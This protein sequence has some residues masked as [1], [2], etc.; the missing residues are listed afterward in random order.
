MQLFLLAL[1]S[2]CSVLPLA[3]QPLDSRLFAGMK[4]REI[5]PYRGG[6][7][8]A[9]AGI[10]N[11]PNVAFIGVSNGGVWKTTDYGHT[12]QSQ[13]D[14]QPVGSIGAIGISPADP[15]TIYVGTGEGLNRPDLAL[16]DG[17]YKSQDG[18]KTWA[19]L[20]LRDSQQIPWISVDPRDPNRLFV[21]AL[22]HPYGPNPERGIF[23]SSD[24]GRTFE[25]VLYKDE[26]T[27]GSFVE[28]DPTDP[29]IVYA[30]LWEARQGPWENSQW[31]GPGGGLF[32]STDGGTTWHP[33][34]KGLPEGTVQVDVTISP[35]D[36]RRLYASVAAGRG[37]SIYSSNDA[38]ESWSAATN[39]PRPASRI[40]GGDL[41]V[42]RVDPK[43]PDVL[44]ITSTVVWKSSDAGKTWTGI[45]GAPGG[46][47]YQNIWINPNDSHIIYI[48][49]DQGAIVSVNGGATWSSWYNQPT[50]AV[51]HVAADN[52]FPY[53]VCS[54]QQDSGSVCVRTRGNDGEITMRDWHPVAVEE[55]GYAAPDPRDPDMVYGGKLTRYNRR[56]GQVQNIAPRPLRGPDFRVVRTEPVIFSPKDPSILYFAS[57]VLW[58][59]RD[60]GNNWKQISQDLTRATWEIPASIGKY[61]GEQSA[62]PAQRGVIYAVGPS[63]LEAGIIW[64][65]TDDGLIHLTR[66]G[67]ATWTNVTPPQLLPWAKVSQLDAGHFDASTAYAAI[68]TIRLDDL[69]PHI[70]RTHD[71]GAT[72]TEIVTGIPADENVNSVRED[73]RTKGL[74]F[75]STERAVYVSF[76]DGAHWQ[77]LRLNMPASSVRDIIIKDDDLIAGTHGRGFWVLD[78]ITPLRQLDSA[79]AHKPLVLFAP[80]T[81]TRVRWDMNPDTPLPPDTPAG[82]NPPDGAILNYYLGSAASGPVTI[83]VQD[84]TGAVVRKYSSADPIPP[85]DP[86]LPIPTYWVRPPQQLETSAGMH[87]FVWDLH[88]AP[89]PG[90][91]PNYPIAAVPHDTAPPPSS[92]WA[93]PGHYK[94]T[95]TANGQSASQTLEVR[96]DPRVKTS[97]ADWQAQSSLSKTLYEQAMQASHAMQM[98]QSL[99]E[100]LNRMNKAGQAAPAAVTDTQQ[101]VTAL[102]GQEQGFFGGGGGRGGAGRQ[103]TVTALRGSL[104]ALLNLVQEADAAPTSQE[105]AAADDLH[106]Q[107]DAL[108]TRFHDFLN[109]LPGINAQLKQAGLPELSLEQRSEPE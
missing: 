85:P 99:R 7:T 58:E 44:Y 59:T 77:S 63:P 61:R 20:G 38:G 9:L 65:G 100:Q 75:A 51:Y 105:A 101:K 107:F 89:V 28:I 64:A 49:S 93:L 55:Y 42:P 1:V 66:D 33:L 97:P 37:V 14:D 30:A 88:W 62:Q 36:P 3:A 39:D 98:L 22:G 25:K 103:D 86:R 70:F 60:G 13:W 81:A 21:A 69:R 31:G 5:G 23:R 15:N 2:F 17:M 16:G 91:R 19:H 41:P 10:P 46:D 40:G 104:L 12:W 6:R 72:W 53:R 47:D 43:N 73:S 52:A 27:G 45:R 57:N 96:M 11:Q 54:G 80:E 108:A 24:G 71:G 84:S 109:S 68:N 67:G 78:D 90:I 94:V 106:R 32:K 92:P 76:D 56:T 26:N 79:T 83:Q 74:L 29:H 95:V 18:G 50:A 87:R 102:L 35:S 4:W 48:T 82:Q 8:R 34:T